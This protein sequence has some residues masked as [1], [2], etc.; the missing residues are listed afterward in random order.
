[1]PFLVIMAFSF[2]QVTIWAGEIKEKCIASES[3]TAKSW[4]SVAE[5]T[6]TYSTN[7]FFGVRDSKYYSISSIPHSS[8]IFGHAFHIPSAKSLA[9]SIEDLNRSNSDFHDSRVH[10]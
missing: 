10:L 1:M 9:H 8:K 3:T 6:L 7:S 4:I 5:E 2:T